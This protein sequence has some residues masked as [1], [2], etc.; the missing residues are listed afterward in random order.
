MTMTC[1]RGAV[2][3]FAFLAALAMGALALLVGRQ[4]QVRGQESDLS[5]DEAA[6][7]SLINNYRSQHGLSTLKVSPTLSAAARWMSEDRAEHGCTGHT[8]SLGRNPLARIR[9]FGYTHA[10]MWGEII[11]CGG[12]TPQE[13]F[14]AWRTSY[15]HNEVMLMGGF[16][17][18]GVG[19]AYNPGTQY[20]YYWTVD[21]GDYDDSNADWPTS[22]PSP[23]ATPSP[24]PSP[25]P[26]ASPTPGSLV[27]CP[28]AGKWSLAAWS[29][30]SGTP[31]GEA[32]ATCTL[33]PVEAAYWLDPDT[34]AWL[35]YF[36]AHPELSSLATLN[37]LQAILALGGGSASPP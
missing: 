1:G 13:A 16:G 32:L 4:P 15:E 11:Q 14:D 20:G 34:Q 22:T 19:K 17:V 30:A 6:V 25:T 28:A 12:R 27:G 29:G 37:N 2:L 31:T 5:P 3:R 10:M 24:T 7:L 33:A 26:T 8:D 9:A 35:R 23:T 18:A 21:F 36:P